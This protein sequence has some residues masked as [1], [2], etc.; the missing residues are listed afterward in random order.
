MSP[1]SVE[2]T[3]P[4]RSADWPNVTQLADGTAEAKNSGLSDFRACVPNTWATFSDPSSQASP[5]LKGA[6]GWTSDNL[7][8]LAVP[9]AS[10]RRKGPY[11]SLAPPASLSAVSLSHPQ[12]GEEQV[13]G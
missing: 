13:L 3:L 1:F 11:W 7:S 8:S 12:D 10:C 6:G 2:E 5:S 4:E 9:A